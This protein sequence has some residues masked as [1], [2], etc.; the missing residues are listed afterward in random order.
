MFHL[1][2]P[3][4][5]PKCFC[6]LRIRYYNLFSLFTSINLLIKSA[7]IISEKP[8]LSELTHPLQVSVN[9]SSFCLNFFAVSSPLLL[10]FLSLLICT[11]SGNYPGIFFFVFIPSNNSFSLPRSLLSSL[12]S[13]SSR[14]FH[15]GCFFSS[16]VTNAARS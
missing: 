5:C 10:V 16:L 6:F 15:Q 11:F 3:N 14:L 2:A 1:L 4:I 12:T 8:V 9:L 13:L 7:V